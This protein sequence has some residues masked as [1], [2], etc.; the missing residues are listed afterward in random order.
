MSFVVE[1]NNEVFNEKSFLEVNAALSLI[2]IFMVIVV[3]LIVVVVGV[4]LEVMVVD[5]I[6][7]KFS[8]QK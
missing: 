2:H 4:V 3:P 6:I 8:N 1:Q 5:M 7:K